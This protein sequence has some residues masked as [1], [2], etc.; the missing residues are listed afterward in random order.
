MLFSPTGRDDAD[1]F[2]AMIVL[3][4][5]VNN[6]QHYRDLSL[7][8][9]RADCVP[10][11]LSCLVYA[12]RTDKA[13]LV[14]EDQRRQLERDSFVFPLI[15]SVL[16]LV[17]FVLHYVD[18]HCIPKMAQYQP[19]PVVEFTK[20]A[21][22]IENYLIEECVGN[23][24]S[25]KM[26]KMQQRRQF[27]D[28][29]LVMFPDRSESGNLGPEALNHAGPPPDNHLEDLLLLVGAILQGRNRSGA[30]RLF[31]SSR[32]SNREGI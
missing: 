7:N 19:Q 27:C 28:T 18:T 11:S 17:P 9:H 8:T 20:N 31:R 24:L 25:V 26:K 6:Q 29:N 22:W 4:V 16:R 23:K 13:A 21:L 32:R 3:S 1:D 14:L 10:P 12:V 15:P 2:F 5:C 30:A